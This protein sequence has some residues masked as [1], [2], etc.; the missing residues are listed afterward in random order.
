MSLWRE[1]SAQHP[2]CLQGTRA[3]RPEAAVLPLLH[4]PGTGWGH[5]CAPRGSEQTAHRQAPFA[6][7]PAGGG[8][9]PRSTSSRPTAPR[10]PLSLPR[11]C[12]ALPWG[13][14]RLAGVRATS[15]ITG[16]LSS[17]RRASEAWRLHGASGA[18]AAFVRAQEPAKPRPALKGGLW[19]HPHLRDEAPEVQDPGSRLTSLEP[20]CRPLPAA[21][22]LRRPGKGAVPVHQTH[23]RGEGDPDTDDL[24]S[25]AC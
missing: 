18:H 16:S 5:P 7:M 14:G 21:A 12:S 22:T 17:W 13:Q 9:V 23:T 8:G 3:P 19:F 1:N 10:A 6:G 15:W 20:A 11:G 24:E 2:P 4:L 25:W